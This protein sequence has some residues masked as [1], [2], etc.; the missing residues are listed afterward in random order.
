M[1]IDNES[2]KLIS[3]LEPLYYI[4][5]KYYNMIIKLFNE[6][7]NMLINDTTNECPTNVTYT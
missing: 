1:Q 7:V 3:E 2:C 5:V 6:L 4:T